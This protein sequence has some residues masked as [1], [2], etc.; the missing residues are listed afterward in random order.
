MQKQI[1]KFLFLLSLFLVLPNFSKAAST[2]FATFDFLNNDVTQGFGNWYYSDIGDN[3]CAVYDGLLQSK[4]CSNPDGNGKRQSM[5][6]YYNG[7][8]SDHMGWLRWAYIDSSPTA[9]S[10]NSLKISFTGGAYNSDGL[11]AVGYSGLDVRSKNQFDNFIS[12]GQNPFANR[13]LPGDMTIY[14]HSNDAN[15]HF[16]PFNQLVGNDRLSV[17]VLPPQDSL[18]NLANQKY[19]VAGDTITS[20][21]SWYPFVNDSNGD[22]YYH[23]LSNI[24]MGGWIHLVFDAHPIHNNGGDTN[25]YSY[26]RAGGYDYPGD[27][28]AFFNNVH[29]FALRGYISGNLPSPSEIY[30]DQMEAYKTTEMENDETIAGIGIGFDPNTKMF[31]I[32]F[33][34]KY[35]CASCD[36]TYEARYSFSPITNANYSSATLLKVT[37][38]DRTK[39][40]SIGIINKVNGG[41]NQL[42]AALDVIDADKAQLI[43]GKKIYFAVKDIS[44][45]SLLVDRDPY[46]EQTVNVPGLGMVRRMDLIKT[47]DYTIYPLLRQLYFENKNLANGHIG[48]AYSE[49][50]PVKGGQKP[51]IA[52]ILSGNLP[53]GLNLSSDGII[54]G[55][56][57]VTG[58]FNMRINIQEASSFNQQ[59]QKDF[60]VNIYD[61]ENCTDGI[62]NDSDVLIDC[63]DPDCYSDSACSVTMVDFAQPNI[64]NLAGWNVLLRDVYTNYVSI[65]PGGMTNVVGSNG[66]YN[67]QGVQGSFRNFIAGDRIMVYWYNDASS[68]ATFIPKISFNDSDRNGSGVVGTWN[69]MSEI[70]IDSKKT[71]TSEFVFDQ[72]TAGSYNIVNINANYN[73][74]QTLICDKIN[75]I[76]FVSSDV[77]APT[78]P[79]GLSVI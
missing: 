64:F 22:H 49:Q 26:H 10:G 29:A 5:N 3:S 28:V 30:I 63:A 17:W 25:P 31:D 67:Y 34:D 14:F 45:R 74:L 11:G 60:V 61:Q 70:T 42:W 47:S 13:L 36:A 1:L 55:T 21:F 51:Y 20:Q 53:A 37:N 46:D 38:F 16:Y 9:I 54:S 78:A 27:S 52:S 76:P 71:A 44:D 57:S 65:G 15:D 77:I 23:D 12:L 19:A 43:E 18:F 4:L 68:A 62:D 6:L 73:N 48:M 58:T 8:N 59:I 33:N 72:T 41:Y 75:L 66:G 40:N 2:D 39:N 32:S 7:Y 24:N 56:P 50:V 35:R 79:N 69:S